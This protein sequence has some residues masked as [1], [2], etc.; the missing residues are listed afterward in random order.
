MSAVYH[1]HRG[2][3]KVEVWEGNDAGERVCVHASVPHE[4]LSRRE[5][6]EAIVKFLVDRF[7]LPEP[8]Y[9][10][11]FREEEID[12]IRKEAG[13]WTEVNERRA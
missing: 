11:I 9:I 2:Y 6:Y 3:R 12:S 1:I 8:K 10:T 7:S 4:H 5:K 13:S